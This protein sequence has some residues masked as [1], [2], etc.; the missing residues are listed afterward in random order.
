MTSRAPDAC[1]GSAEW[2]AFEA[3]G[4]QALTAFE[5]ESQPW[6]AVRCW[7]ADIAEELVA[8]E[9]DGTLPVTPG[10]AQVWITREGRAVLLD[11]KERRFSSAETNE[12]RLETAAPCQQAQS[13]LDAMSKHALDPKTVPLHARDVLQKLASAT[14]DRMSFIAGN[15]QSLLA[16]PATISIRRRA[17]SLCIVPAAV[18]LFVALI[19]WEQLSSNAEADAFW[20]KRHPD[21]S[22]LSAVL[23]LRDVSDAGRN[24]LFA[25]KPDLRVHRATTVHIAQHYGHELAG[26]LAK[27]P[28]E[29]PDT[30]LDTDQRSEIAGII[31]HGA[32][33]DYPESFKATLTPEMRNALTPPPT[34]QEIASS[35]EII[36]Q[37]LPAFLTEES[38]RYRICGINALR[39]TCI[40]IAI[41]QFFTLLIFGTTLGQRVFG[42]AVL[43]KQGAVAGRL[44][45]LGRWCI[46]WIP[47]ILVDARI[48]IHEL[49]HQA[50]GTADILR[51][52]AFGGLWVLGVIAA[53][54]QPK[55]GIHDDHV[56]TW[57]VPR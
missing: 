8:A 18:A 39:N 24:S 32:A 29:D 35:D 33:P 40:V 15:L 21:Q 50:W 30:P 6:A 2:N 7:L 13:L 17:V 44:R 28:Q 11:D 26:S 31:I 10:I 45:M 14:F 16:R 54:M 53:I 36:K 57:L 1:A 48:E 43:N 9:K 3:P 19:G 4:G 22:P 37:A 12:R 52:V 34:P 55:Q 42:F 41:V 5:K 56:K 20:K 46:A 49:F 27:S 47:F 25:W 51:C 23:R 38:T